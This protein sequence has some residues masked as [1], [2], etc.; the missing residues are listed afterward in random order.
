MENTYAKILGNHAADLIART[1]RLKPA[2]LAVKEP[3][4]EMP[5]CDLAVRIDFRGQPAEGPG[6]VSGSV[7]AAFLRGED[8]QAFLE[9]LAEHFDIN[10]AVLSTAE[11]RAN[12]LSEFLNI[13]VGLTG[14][15]WD[16][17]GLAIDFSP[18]EVVAGR[19]PGASGGRRAYLVSIT[20]EPPARLDL[21]V[22]FG[23]GESAA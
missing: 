7:Y 22:S 13:I 8:A 6:P 11:G 14:A 20:T 21:L 19:L 23:G 5:A 17:H 10:P 9:P 16:E 18:P 1:S 12:V 15:D 4:A 2:G 3:P